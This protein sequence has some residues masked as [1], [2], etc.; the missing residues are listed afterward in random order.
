MRLKLGRPDLTRYA[1]LF[2]VPAGDGDVMVTF[3][4]VSTL[5]FDDGDSAVLFDG[6]FS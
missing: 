4:G 6:F 2:D 3:L 1:D 5:L